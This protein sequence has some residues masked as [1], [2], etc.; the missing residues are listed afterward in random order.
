MKALIHGRILLEDREM[1]D[2]AL[3]FD[4]KIDL[5]CRIV[6][7]GDHS[8][9]SWERQIPFFMHTLLYEV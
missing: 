9:A 4:K 8:E 6:P 5:A 1:P 2:A 3:L 7:M